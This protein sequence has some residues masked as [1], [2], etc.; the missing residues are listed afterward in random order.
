MKKIFFILFTFF[1]ISC[2]SQFS[3]TH[4]I[5]PLVAQNNLAEDQ[6]LYISTPNTSSVN[7]KIIE[8]GGNIITGVVSNGTPYIY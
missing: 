6:Y 4:Y 2:F 5:P 7:L 3:K 1:S 8:I